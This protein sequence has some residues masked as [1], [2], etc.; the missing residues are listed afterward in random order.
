MC[1]NFFFFKEIHNT[2][3]L[4]VTKH[5]SQ[6]GK[7]RMISIGNGHRQLKIGGKMVGMVD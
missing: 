3:E 6:L 7:D 1:F 2:F 4:D 5:S